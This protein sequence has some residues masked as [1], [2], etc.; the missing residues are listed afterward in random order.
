MGFQKATKE[1]SKLRLAIYGPAGSGK[2]FTAL[3]IAKGIVGPEG[4][5]AVIDTERGTASKYADRFDFDVD[6]VQTATIA[7]LVAELKEVVAGGYDCLIIDS[8]SHYWHDLLAEVERI[9]KAKY[10][11]N[12]WSAW[13]EGTPKQRLLIDALMAL[14]CHLIWTMRS[15]TEWTTEGENK[16]KPV[17][18]GLSPEQ[19]KGIEYEA[20]LLMSIS[21]EHVAIIEKDRTGKFQDMTMERPGE[22]FGAALRAW[23]SE[24]AAP[25][26]KPKGDATP[27]E[28]FMAEMDKLRRL[29]VAGL[30]QL[31]NSDDPQV[32]FMARFNRLCDSLD[33]PSDVDWDM[34]PQLVSD[35]SNRLRLYRSLQEMAAA[36]AKEHPLPTP[37]QSVAAQPAA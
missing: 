22:E 16:N 13:S 36:L 24:G 25:A 11:G 10:R 37:D 5:I 28:K 3:R 18:V 8:L 19:G 29:A 21:I 26:P 2:T 4:R 30:I 31:D 32:E 33:L 1:Q 34:L 23:L 27:D 15:K 17:R 35:R 20:D 14:P 9:A 7:S 12:T 6:N